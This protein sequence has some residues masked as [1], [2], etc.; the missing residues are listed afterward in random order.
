M[1]GS[2]G[3]GRVFRAGF[4]VA[5]LFGVVACAGGPP[6]TDEQ[7]QADREMVERVQAAL[8]ADRA[9][10]A[11]HISIRA[12]NGVVRLTGYVWTSPDMIEAEETVAAVPG[13]TRVLNDLELQQ[14]GIDNSGVSR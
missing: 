10:Y 6:K 7:R 1:I 11:K 9:L 3:G 8:D 5:L 14:N 2:P 12:D 4:A 13:V